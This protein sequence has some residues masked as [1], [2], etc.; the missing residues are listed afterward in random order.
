MLAT[1]E[2]RVLEDDNNF[3]PNHRF[4]GLCSYC[5]EPIAAYGRNKVNCEYHW[6]KRKHYSIKNSCEN[7]NSENVADKNLHLRG[8]FC[9]ISWQKFILWAYEHDE[10]KRLKDPALLRI[11]RGKD[12]ELSNIRWGEMKEIFN[13]AHKK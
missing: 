13:A 10:Y 11:D 5:N 6:L 3:K 1:H 2:K 9:K 12:Y 4:I 8:I 7:A